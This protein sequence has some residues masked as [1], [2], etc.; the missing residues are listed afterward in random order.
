[1]RFEN[2]RQINL[3]MYFDMFSVKGTIRLEQGFPHLTKHAY[4][5]SLSCQKG[6]HV[7]VTNSPAE[8]NGGN[9]EKSVNFDLPKIPGIF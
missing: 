5:P 1:M 6:N 3:R 4:K 7:I 2:L 9:V 8:W